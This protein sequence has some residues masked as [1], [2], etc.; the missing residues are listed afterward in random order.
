MSICGGIAG[1]RGRNPLGAIIH[2]DAGGQN[3]NAGFY[4]IWL[5]THD[6]AAGFAHYYVASD[7]TLQAEDDTNCAW[8]CGNTNGNTGYLSFEACQSMGNLAVFQINEDNTLKLVAQKFKQY[9]ILPNEN[10]VRLHQE[11]SSTACPHRSVEIHGGAAATK[12]YFIGKIK[13]YMG[14]NTDITPAEG[15]SP[16]TIIWNSTEVE[17]MQQF[18]TIDKGKTI[19][20][21]NGYDVRALAHPDEVI[22][23]NEIYKQNNNKN[24]PVVDYNSKAPYYKRLLAVLNRKPVVAL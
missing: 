2:N 19:Y 20:Y 18:F 21:F 1:C 7:Y 11:F 16:E 5:R 10:T 3:A 23:L 6:L 13:Q 22:A 14:M 8:H 4:N 15:A 12:Q 9:G 17:D 24:I